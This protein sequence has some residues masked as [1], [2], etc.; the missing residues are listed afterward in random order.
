MARPGLSALVLS[1]TA[2]GSTC[3]GGQ[4]TLSACN[5]TGMCVAGS[6]TT[7]VNGCNMSG[8]LCATPCTV[9]ANCPM[10][11]YCNMGSC[12]AKLNAGAACGGNNECVSGVCGTAGS[13][14]CCTAA[15]TTGGTCGAT[16]CDATGACVAPG[17]STPCG[18]SC[19][20]STLTTSSCNGGGGCVANT[21]TA[22]PGGLIC[23][24]ATS[25]LATCT[26]T[27]GRCMPLTCDEFPSTDPH[28]VP[29]GWL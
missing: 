1:M 15:C 29:P 4:E 19:T 13:G 26:P 28:C 11:S 7:C 5:G 21:P 12:D 27:P 9:D 14:N 20:G 16:G 23:A 6:P 8:T 17:S 25:C 3:T 2:C 24:D 10:G 18:S 22:C